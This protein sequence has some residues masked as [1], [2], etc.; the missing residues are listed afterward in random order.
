[1]A[2]D[3]NMRITTSDGTE[4]S[5]GGLRRLLVTVLIIALILYVGAYFGLQTDGARSLLEGWVSRKTGMDVKIGECR[6]AFPA[7][8]RMQFVKAGDPAENRPG[9]AADEM[10]LKVS[11][12]GRLVMHLKGL[13]LVL[14]SEQDGVWAPRFL[15]RLGDLPVRSLDKLSDLTAGFRSR[16]MVNIDG[17]VL[18]WIGDEGDVYAIM[19]G[20]DFSMVPVSL[21]GRRLTCYRLDVYKFEI[22]GDAGAS[23]RDLSREWLA[24]D[25]LPYVSLSAS[26]VF[27]GESCLFADSRRELQNEN[28]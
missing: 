5:T 24:G 2:K 15:S 7:G 28:Q 3:R 16:L 8:V 21:P 27:S 6:L 26:G 1:M 22:D 19:E 17:A 9:F 4:R 18:K 11:A 13:D 12:S 20:V 10:T 14:A 25:D 23:G